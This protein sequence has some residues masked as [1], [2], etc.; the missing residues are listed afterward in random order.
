MFRYRTTR[1]C[2]NPA[3][4]LLVGTLGC[5]DSTPQDTHS[6]GDGTSESD[7]SADIDLSCT[8]VTLTFRAEVV[9]I[10]G[11]PFGLTSESDRERFATGSLTYDPCVPDTDPF[12]SPDH[13]EFDH[14]F[15]DRG[16]FNVTLEPGGTDL[17]VVGSSR[18]VAG[19]RN[20]D[21][22]D[23]EDGG[24]DM[25]ND[26]TRYLTVN[27]AEDEEAEVRFTIGGGEVDFPSDAL[28]EQFPM[29]GSSSE[30]FDCVQ[31]TDFCV[32]FSIHEST[33]GDSFLMRLHAL[34]Q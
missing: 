28:P 8:P 2:V 10:A 34:T 3:S 26:L 5:E 27:G 1:R 23:F 33:F 11:T 13:G 20:L 24:R 18:P 30:D 12:D 31:S 25:S 9:T 32:T 19:I 29:T 22:F 17:S 6:P 4:L 7:A 16:A 21:Y 15:T 14:R